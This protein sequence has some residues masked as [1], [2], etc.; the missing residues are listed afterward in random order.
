MARDF[1][2]AKPDPFA[3]AGIERVAKRANVVDLVNRIGADHI[4][5]A[6]RPA[7]QL[8]AMLFYD[9]DVVL[10]VVHGESL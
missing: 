1:W 5:E 4:R 7:N 10:E 2:F 3:D 9:L 6:R 8:D